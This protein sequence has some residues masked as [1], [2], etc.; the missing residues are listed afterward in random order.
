M[1]CLILFYTLEKSTPPWACLTQAPM[2]ERL[3]TFRAPLTWSHS[4]QT[5]CCSWALH[6][7]SWEPYSMRTTP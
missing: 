1:K 3:Q 4:T 6:M 5:H 7:R 2:T